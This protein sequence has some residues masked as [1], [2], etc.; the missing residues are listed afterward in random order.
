MVSGRDVTE[1]AWQQTVVEVARLYGWR[2]IFHAPHG[3]QAG[4]VA[5]GQVP[6]GT[7]FP[8]LLMVKGPRLIVAELKTRIGKI[9]PGQM[10]WLEALRAVGGVEAYLWRPADWPEVQRVLRGAAA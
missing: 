6:E 4:R 10:E 2:F 9:R 5:L 3:G 8:D 1:K 7:G